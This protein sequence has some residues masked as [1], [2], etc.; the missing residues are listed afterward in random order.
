MAAWGPDPAELVPIAEEVRGL[1]ARTRAPANVLD[2]LTVDSIVAW[3]TLAEA[4]A[5]SLDDRYDALAEDLG[6]SAPRWQAAMQNVVWALFRG[7]F[8][9]AERLAEEAAAHGGGERRVDAEC[10]YRLAMFVLRRE[11]GR[12]AELEPLVRA[13]P[14]AY[15]GYR[16]FRCFVPL[17]DLELGRD[18]AARQALT[19]LAA[20]GFGAFP[21]DGEWLFCLS[22]LA[23]VAVAVAD[24][25]AAET[26]YGL[27]QP[28]ARINV[29]AVGE[30]AVGP[31]ARFLGLLATAL[32]RAEEAE[33][34]FEAAIAMNARISGRP[35][36]ARAQEG[37]ARMLRERGQ[38]GD[39]ERARELLAACTATYRELGMR[40]A[41]RRSGARP[42][43]PPQAR[44]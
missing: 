34:H 7:D 29:M 21:R 28:Y 22:H 10:S 11:Q 15:P 37:H 17:L 18:A 38:P 33:A 19:A 36:L 23:E 43:R 9:E 13:A 14:A 8:A 2:A 31:A 42:R 41:R 35:W 12:L 4:D 27:L 25:G 44:P 40:P 6:E 32:G 26:L 24:R 16:T 1:A 30:V 39:A 5:A 20:D 3:L